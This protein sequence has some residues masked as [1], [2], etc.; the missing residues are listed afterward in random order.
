[1]AYGSGLINRLQS[2]IC[3]LLFAITHLLSA[4][5]YL[6]IFHC[7]FQP[8]AGFGRVPEIEEDFF[9]LFLALED[10][11]HYFL[12]SVLFNLREGF[13]S[14]PGGPGPAPEPS[15]GQWD[16]EPPGPVSGWRLFYHVQY[17]ALSGF[18]VY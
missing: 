18:F 1:M 8:C 17:E 12:D 16:W 14:P 6:E 4:I 2:V 13:V 5:C 11:L 9:F 3:N 10:P 15:P 7:F